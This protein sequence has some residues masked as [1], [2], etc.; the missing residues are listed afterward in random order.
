MLGEWI[1][2]RAQNSPIYEK[3]NFFLVGILV[4][5]CYIHAIC[6]ILILTLNE[7]FTK[8]NITSKLRQSKN[9]VKV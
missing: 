9:L 5:G 4:F 3:K 7:E 6:K 8:T 2:E 1:R